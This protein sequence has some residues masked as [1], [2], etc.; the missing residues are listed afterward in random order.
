MSGRL[1]A[2]LALLGA[3]VAGVVIGLL[4]IAPAGPDDAAAPPA[5]QPSPVPRSTVSAAVTPAPDADTAA[6]TVL[7]HAIADAI[8]RRDATEFGTLTC[9]A[10]TADALS[11]LQKRWDA[12]GPMTVTLPGAPVVDGDSAS[13]QIHVQSGG[14][15]KD[16][17]FPMRREHDRWCVPG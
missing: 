2:G 15:H 6:V 16:T 5:S 1:T 9:A 8:E 3:L 13:V 11:A 12:A 7:A 10:Q 17:P 4:L 14:G